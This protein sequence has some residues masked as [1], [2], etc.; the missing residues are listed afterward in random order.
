MKS[1]KAK[2][3]KPGRYPFLLSPQH[4][5]GRV[6]MVMNISSDENGEISMLLIYYGN[7]KGELRTMKE[8]GEKKTLTILEVLDGT[9]D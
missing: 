9:E 6:D 3:K 5:K 8:K 2:W 7:K 1:S 4:L